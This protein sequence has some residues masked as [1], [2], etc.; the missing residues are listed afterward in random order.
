MAMAQPQLSVKL[1]HPAQRL[2]EVRQVFRQQAEALNAISRRVGPEVIEAIELMLSVRG[3][4]IVTGM[5][6]SGIVGRKMA[7][8]LSSTGTPAF[9]VHP[10]EA[11]HGDLGMICADDVV[12]LIS[13]SGETDEVLR[14]LP[15][16]RHIRVPLIAMTGKP[17][18]TL[19]RHATVSLDVA[20]DSECCPHNL[21]PTTSTTAT[22]AMGD[23]LAIA[24][25]NARGFLPTDFAKFHPGGSLGRKLLT[26]VRDV[27]HTQYARL[28][29][30]DPFVRV[31]N[32][33]TRTRL[34]LATVLDEDGRLLGVISDGDLVRTMQS[35]QAGQMLQRLAGDIMTRTPVV[36]SVDAMFTDAENLMQKASVTCLVAVDSAGLP[37]GIVKVFD[38]LN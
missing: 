20:V 8:T 36:V 22:L 13:Y 4:V 24:L 30:G 23:A 31:L 18:S 34:G 12:L 33:V 17:V 5:G 19:A 21:A 2:N 1:S 26:R 15:Y 3:R 10:G 9:F 27:M 37:C 28:L 35:D 32:A 7:A 38:V 25:I 16:L 29:P 6:K 14:L 11:F